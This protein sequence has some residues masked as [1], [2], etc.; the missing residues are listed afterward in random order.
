VQHLWATGSHAVNR[1]PG[2]DLTTDS[3]SDLTTDSTTD[4]TTDPTSG[5]A[6]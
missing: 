4:S 6:A 3:T 1:L 5:T 2:S